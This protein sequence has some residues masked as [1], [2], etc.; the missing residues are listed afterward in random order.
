MQDIDASSILHG[1]DNY[2]IGQF[3]TLWNWISGQITSGDLSM[4]RVAYEEISN[5]SPDC[6][7]WL[8]D[9]QI[10][11]KDITNAIVIAAL[12]I[13][14]ELGIQNDNFH[15][16]G[17]GEND[18]FIIATAK[19]SGVRLISDESKQKTLPSNLRRYKMPTVCDMQSV[20]V[21]CIN[22]VEYIKQSN[23]VFG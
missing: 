10:T 1:W 20:A 16:D 8:R 7:E 22:F 23:R 9:C 14:D 12:A 2:P 18:I 4:S 17:V 3:P 11:R 21:P 13:K 6:A 19:V 5:V 15:T